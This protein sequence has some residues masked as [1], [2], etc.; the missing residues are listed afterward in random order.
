MKIIW[1]SVCDV[2]NELFQATVA[3][4]VEKDPV[5]GPHFPT[6]LPEIGKNKRTASHLSITVWSIRCVRIL[7]VTR[8]QGFLG[9][10][11]LRCITIIPLREYRERALENVVLSGALRCTSGAHCVARREMHAGFGEGQGKRAYGGL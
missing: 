4:V 2:K 5:K 3:E 8:A 11:S 6:T 1:T 10:S 9:V 7:T